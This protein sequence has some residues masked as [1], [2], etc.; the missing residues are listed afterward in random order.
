MSEVSVIALDLAKHVFQAHGADASGR[1]VLRKLVAFALTPG[2]VPDIHRAIPLLAG[3]SRPKRL[4]ADKAY[5][6]MSLRRWLKRRRIRAVIPSLAT[7][8]FPFPLD[9]KA[10]KRRTAIERMWS[11]LG[12]GA[13]S[14]PGSR[15]LGP[16]LPRQAGPGVRRRGS[17]LKEAAA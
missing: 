12:P 1:V 11:R 5:D 2:H 13:V 10:C 3:L 16:Q 6:A 14:P 8:S 7:R 15:P 17:D 9:R 4:I